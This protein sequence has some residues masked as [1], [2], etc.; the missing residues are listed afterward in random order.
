MLVLVQLPWC[1]IDVMSIAAFE[2][3]DTLASLLHAQLTFE[4]VFLFE[5]STKL[6]LIDG[7]A[8]VGAQCW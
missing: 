1:I 8:G 7:V 6:R 4:L 5:G 3:Q 2:L